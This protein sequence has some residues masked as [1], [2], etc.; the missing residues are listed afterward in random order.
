MAH[1]FLIFFVGE[2]RFGI[3]ASMVAE[4]I[5][6]AEIVRVP[7]VDATVAGITFVRG[8][9]FAVLDTARLLGLEADAPER[10]RSGR[11]MLVSVAGL[12]AGLLVT[13]TGDIATF[14]TESLDPMPL[15]RLGSAERRVALG[16]VAHGTDD[17]LAGTTL[18]DGELLLGAA[19]ERACA[20]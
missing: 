20:T 11:V 7:G 14:S 19:K 13:R 1:P 18:L 15:E 9:V 10:I 5:A 4:V 2:S 12:E 6:N 3:D 17:K 16:V 8:R